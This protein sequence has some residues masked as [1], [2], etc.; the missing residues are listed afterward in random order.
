M[1]WGGTPSCSTVQI[2]T[3]R[4][5]FQA[6]ALYVIELVASNVDAPGQCAEYS[7]W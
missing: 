3:Y 1:S 4:L 5:Y 6:N 2:P 7:V